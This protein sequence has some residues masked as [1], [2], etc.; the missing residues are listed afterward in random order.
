M[1]DWLRAVIAELRANPPPLDAGEIAE[2]VQFLEWLAADNFTLLGARDYAFTG[3]TDVLEPMFETGLGLLRSRDMRPLQRWNQPLVIT[4]EIRDVPGGA[5]APRH[6]QV[7]LA[8]AGASPRRY[9]LYRRQAFRPARQA[10]RRIP[11]LRPVHLDRLYALGARHSLSAA[12]GRRHHPP[13]RLR[14]MRA[15]PA[16]RWSTCWRPIRA[17]NCSRSTKTCSIS[18]RWPSFSSTSV[19]GC[20]CCRGATASTALSR[21]SFTFRASATTARSGR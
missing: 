11:P 7:D 9:G 19:R 10:G 13:R 14:S 5:P 8:L 21:S 17:T 12:Q 2:G 3:N 4:P 15:I 20:A 1:L 18:S 16:R 6:H